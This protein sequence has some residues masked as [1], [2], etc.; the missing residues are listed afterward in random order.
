MIT[1]RSETRYLRAFPVSPSTVARAKPSSEATR[2]FVD[3]VKSILSTSV[4]YDL[5]APS[6]RVVVLEVSLPLKVAFMAAMETNSSYCVLWDREKQQVAGIMTATDYIKILL[7]CHRTCADAAQVDSMREMS[8]KNWRLEPWMGKKPKDC[9]VSYALKDTAFDCMTRLHENHIHRMP[10]LQSET[11]PTICGLVSYPPILAHLVQSYFDMNAEDDVLDAAVEDIGIGRY[12]AEKV[13][14]VTMQTTLADA[15]DIF[16]SDVVHVLPIVDTQNV[17]VDVI[18]RNDVLSLDMGQ[19]VFDLSITLG[20]VLRGRVTGS[21]YV[22]S[23]KDTFRAVVTH[24]VR[25]GVPTL[26]AVDGEDH[27]CGIVSVTDVFEFL[28]IVTKE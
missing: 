22:Y 1:Q 25:S 13:R 7:H 4:C 26:I 27:V 5:L 3:R 18:S 11:D 20:D 10:V 17:V 12:G 14:T 24:F 16:L 21:I 15:F 8:I 23:P 19:G 6:G 2:H 9:V 28:H